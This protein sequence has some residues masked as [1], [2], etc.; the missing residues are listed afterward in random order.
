MTRARRQRDEVAPSLFPFLAVL[1]C[2]MGALVVI[3]MLVVASAQASAKQ[4]VAEKE[5]H[6]E[7]VESQIELARDAY[8]EQLNSGQIELEKKRLVLQHL[9]NHIQELLTKLADLESTRSLLLTDTQQQVEETT[10]ELSELEKQLLDAKEKLKN[11]LESPQGDKPIFAVIPY[12]GPNGTHRRPIYLEC[13]DKG[14]TIQPEGVTLQ[15]DDL[16]PPYGPGNPLDAALRTIR[17]EF[18][19]ANHAVTST[20]YPLLIVRPSGVSVYGAARAAMSGWDDQFGYEL[21]EEELEL[22][23]PPSQPGLEQKIA[24]ALDLA[25]QR[26]A[27][28]IMA[29]PHRFQLLRTAAAD[30]G[31]GSRNAGGQGFADGRDYADLPNGEGYGG[32]QSGQYETG[33]GDTNY[34]QFG[35]GGIALAPLNATA[36]ALLGNAGENLGFSSGDSTAFA[37]QEPSIARQGSEGASSFGAS[38]SGSSG[39]IGSDFASGS[40]NSSNSSQSADSGSNRSSDNSAGAGAA[41]SLG[42]PGNRM[43]LPTFGMQGQQSPQSQTPD[44]FSADGSSRSAR[45]G[46]RNP[47]S[48][49]G[50]ASGQS[51]TLYDASPNAQRNANSSD[52]GGSVAASHG[53]DWAWS[54]G[55]SLRTS[56]V[57]S[58]KFRCAQDHWLLLPDAS[59]R[60]REVRIDFDG[61]PVERAEQ[62]AE[63]IRQRVA[64]W[65]LALEGGTWKPVLQVEVEPN[66]EWRFEQLQ[67]LFENSGLEIRRQESTP[68]A[69]DSR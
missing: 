23:F 66:A 22:A 27:A 24:T 37:N 18:V 38:L 62:L 12:D 41:Q 47:N 8:Q 36:D 43:A 59:G 1:L 39:T 58:I 29:M 48:S 67:R 68:A 64:S 61:S 31:L 34:S 25:R 19:P 5:L 63:L 32:A 3:L 45:N 49:T 7:E 15:A 20:A 60:S 28:L 52:S 46:T 21:V 4:V 11:K 50:A 16:M 14:L 30:G 17:S 56:V 10:Q 57:R 35:P 6:N 13:T 51:S 9:E 53:R 65:G 2:T 69:G 26:Q 44:Q 40:T 54:Q 55:P 42:A 33:S